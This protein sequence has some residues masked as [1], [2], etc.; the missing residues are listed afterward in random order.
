MVYDHLLVTIPI[1]ATE[2]R[3]V[4]SW[5]IDELMRGKTKE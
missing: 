5:K 4:G 2:D 1:N 3:L